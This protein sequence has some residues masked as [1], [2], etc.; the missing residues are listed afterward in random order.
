[1]VVVI[2]RLESLAHSVYTWCPFLPSSRFTWAPVL[3]WT[4]PHF[5]VA[6]GSENMTTVLRLWRLL[7]GHGPSDELEDVMDLPN[8]FQ[9]EGNTLLPGC[10]MH[11]SRSAPALIR[12]TTENVRVHIR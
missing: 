4:K 9:T 3:L 1:M 5:L 12:E 7:Q 10:A 2:L 6:H 8:I 11:F